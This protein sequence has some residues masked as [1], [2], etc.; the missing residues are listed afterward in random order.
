MV[1]LYKDSKSY[2]AKPYDVVPGTVSINYDDKKA[3]CAG[4]ISYEIKWI[5]YFEHFFISNYIAINNCFYLLQLHKTYYHVNKIK[6]ESNNE[7]QEID[8]KNREFYNFDNI[9][10]IND[11]DLDNMLLS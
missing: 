3:T 11:L 4:G 9:I 2:D 7:L 10:D 6:M 8:I 1:K 5:L